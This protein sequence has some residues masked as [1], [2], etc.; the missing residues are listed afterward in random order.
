MK[1]QHDYGDDCDQNTNSTGK[2]KKKTKKLTRCETEGKQKVGTQ[3]MRERG[4]D[5]SNKEQ[6]QNNFSATVE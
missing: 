4:V 6:P 2:H 5:K 3:Q 1:R